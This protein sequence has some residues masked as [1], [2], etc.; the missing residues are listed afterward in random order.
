MINKIKTLEEMHP[1][2]ERLLSDEQYNRALCYI[3]DH[4]IPYTSNFNLPS[5]SS[6]KIQSLYYCI[7]NTFYFDLTP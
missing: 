7:C 3:Q 4:V 5:R 2:L 6:Q 1:V